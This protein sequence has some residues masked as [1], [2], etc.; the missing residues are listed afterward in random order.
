MNI[1]IVDDD[2][3][4]A[5]KLKKDVT[6]YF[7]NIKDLVVHVIND[8]FQK[9]LQADSVDVLFLDIDLKTK[10]NGIHLARYIKKIFPDIILIFVSAHDHF[11]FPALSVGFFQF[12]RKEKYDMDAPKVFL[13]VRKYIDENIK[14]V[15]ITVDGRKTLLKVHEIMYILSIGHDLIIKTKNND[16]TIFSPIYKFLEKVQYPDLVQIQKNL[17]INLNYSKSVVRKK[18]IMLDGKEY[19]VG[20]KYQNEL[21][22]IYEEFLLK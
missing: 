6:A 1:F 20:R 16:Y 4:F 11:V 7:S 15:L 19:V 21:L 13:Q 2:K 5:E 22:E 14:K 17:V 18:V 9:I 3:K 8:D 10:D 12:I